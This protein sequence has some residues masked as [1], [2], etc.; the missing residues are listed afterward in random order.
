MVTAENAE[1]SYKRFKEEKPDLVLMDYMMPGT[2]G[3]AAMEHIREI[4]GDKHTPILVLTADITSDKRE[5][6][7][8]KGFD[9]CLYK[10]IDWVK[11]EKELSEHLP[12]RLVTRIDS[13]A[14][15]AYRKETIE[16]YAEMLRN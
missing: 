1:E 10:P 12:A 11:L 3:I 5:L 7:M 13:R 8:S 4:D 2:D 16:D 15:A 6:F 9:G 14:G